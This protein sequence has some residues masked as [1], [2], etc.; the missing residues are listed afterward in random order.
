[1][2][3]L[4]V[5]GGRDWMYNVN[6]KTLPQIRLSNSDFS[7]KAEYMFYILN[8]FLVHKDLQILVG[9]ANGVDFMVRLWHL[10]VNLTSKTILNLNVFKADWDKYGKAAGPI[11]NQ[12]MLDQ[13]PNI[14][15]AFPGGKGTADMVKRAKVV[16]LKVIELNGNI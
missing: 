13:E 1:M 11:R 8:H 2:Y 16:G 7:R 15:I 10:S 5:T 4:L 14:V 6:S 3:K 12:E 9:D